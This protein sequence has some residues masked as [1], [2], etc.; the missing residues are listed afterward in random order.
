MQSSSDTAHAPQCH[1]LLDLPEHVFDSIMDHLDAKVICHVLRPSCSQVRD[2][3]NE[4]WWL[5]Y[6]NRAF[7]GYTGLDCNR[8]DLPS[9]SFMHMALRYC[10]LLSLQGVRWK[11]LPNFEFPSEGHAGVTI[12][13]NVWVTSAPSTDVTTL[14][15]QRCACSLMLCAGSCWI[16]RPRTGFAHA[17]AM[18]RQPRVHLAHVCRG[19]AGQSRHRLQ[20]RALRAFYRSSWRFAGFVWWLAVRYDV[21]KWNQRRATTC[22]HFN[23]QQDIKT[24]ATGF[25]LSTPRM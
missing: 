11:R 24:S 14:V 22:S 2:R 4:Q 18:L 3:L 10:A 6:C 17:R 21:S 8:D 5:Q 9:G 12:G 19:A 1:G 7:S 20:Q 25:S 13:R 23:N 16:Q 15:L